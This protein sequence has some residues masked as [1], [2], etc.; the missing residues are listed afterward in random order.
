M[1]A[2]VESLDAVP[3][4]NRGEYEQRDGKFVLKLE[5]DHPEVAG[6]RNKV[7]EFRDNNIRLMKDLDAA[8]GKLK[9][10]DG[11]DPNEYVTLKT[12]VADFEK[13]GKDPNSILDVTRKQ[14]EA[15]TQPLLEKLTAI[16]AKEKAANAALA[17]KELEATLTKAAMAV[18]VSESAVQDFIVRGAQVFTYEDGKVVAKNGDSPVFSKRH[19]AAMLDVIEWAEDLSQSA[20]H[21][22]KPSKGANTPGGLNTPSPKKFVNGN[23]PLEFGRNIDGIIKGEVGVVTTL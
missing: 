21:L 11:V 3:E 13:L 8:T 7:A 6:H 2:V 17:R 9:A 16:E 22:F 12:R 18:G 14:V 1:K 19:P 23:D 10:F 5:G 20:P 15:A 4:V